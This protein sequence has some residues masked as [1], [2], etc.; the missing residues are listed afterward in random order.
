MLELKIELIILWLNETD[1]PIVAALD[2]VIRKARKIV[3]C[4]SRH[5]SSFAF[6][7]DHIRRS[8]KWYWAENKSGV[9]VISEIHLD[10]RLRPRGDVGGKR[11]YLVYKT[12]KLVS[13]SKI[14]DRNADSPKRL[15]NHQVR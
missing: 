2:N 5:C 8:T 15:Q 12:Y 3:P 7:N 13:N 10:K 4:A 1:A 6:H 9:L 11:G 14:A